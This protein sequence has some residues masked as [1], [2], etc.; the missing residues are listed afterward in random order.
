MILNFG[1]LYWSVLISSFLVN[2]FFNQHILS[3]CLINYSDLVGIADDIKIIINID[4]D[5][6]IYLIFNIKNFLKFFFSKIKLK[7]K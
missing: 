5:D 2:D 1:F 4:G 7:K 3:N 6:L